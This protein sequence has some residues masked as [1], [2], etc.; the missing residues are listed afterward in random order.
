MP[1]CLDRPASHPGRRGATGR[2]DPM[3]RLSQKPS[4]PPPKPAFICRSGSGIGWAK[5]KRAHHLSRKQ[6]GTLRFAH[7]TPLESPKTHTYLGFARRRVGK[8]ERAH[9]L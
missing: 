9:L 1:V 4:E 2:T 5:R 8:A 6:M 7:P 3:A